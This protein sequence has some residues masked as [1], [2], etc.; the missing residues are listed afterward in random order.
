MEVVER[1]PV[2]IYE[3]VCTECKSKIQYKA[4]EIFL[5]HITCPVCGVSLWANTIKPVRM[6]EE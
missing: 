6:E 2:P 4:A 5:S 1:K 3:I